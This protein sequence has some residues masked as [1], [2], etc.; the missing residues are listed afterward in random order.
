MTTSGMRMTNGIVRLFVALGAIA[1]AAFVA[2]GARLQEL[3]LISL[4]ALPVLALTG[5]IVWLGHRKTKPA[6]IGLSNGVVRLFVAVAAVAVAAFIASGVALQEASLILMGAIP[7]LALVGAIIWF[8]NRLM[9]NVETEERS[10]EM[11]ELTY[12]S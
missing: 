7:T 2:S 11:M 12:G 1:V 8:A 10:E 9:A 4:S 5:G 6:G 3:A